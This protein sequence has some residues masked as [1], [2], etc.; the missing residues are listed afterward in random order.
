MRPVTKYMHRNLLKPRSVNRAGIVRIVLVSALA[1]FG[2]CAAPAPVKGLFPPAENAPSKNIY[3][4]S[5]G[6][7]AG[8]VMQ[9]VDIPEG[10]CT[11]H[12][13]DFREARYLEVGWGDQDFYQTPEPT[14]GM[15]LKAALFPTK[16][17]LHVVGFSDPVRN[18]F[19]NSEIIEIALSYE[20]FEQLCKYIEQSYAKN[21]RGEVQ[22]L[23][24]G[25]YGNSQF[26][27]SRESYHVFKTC[28]VWTARALRAAGCPVAPGRLIKVESLMSRARAFGKVIQSKPASE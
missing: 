18:Y 28:N 25:L 27:Q 17:V 19:P 12:K 6:W 4:V 21:E 22:V 3:L 14:L 2:G 5:H 26:Y 20:G 16:S 15:K 7:H 1:V 8:I 23:G 9:R 24:P 10:V 13:H 11:Q